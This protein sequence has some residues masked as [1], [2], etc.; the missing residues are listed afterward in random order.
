MA[1]PKILKLS[2]FLAHFASDKRKDRKFCFITGAGASKESGIRTGAELV[3]VWMDDT[4]T[5]YG[6]EETARW[7]EENDIDENTLAPHYSKIY[8]KRFELD[9]KEGFDFLENEMERAKPSCGYS[10]LVQVLANTSHNIVITVNFDSMVEDAMFTYTDKRPLV[11]GH[12]SLAGFIGPT[13]TR[14]LIAKI[15]RDVFLAP[16]S[17]LAETA[18][19]AD[20]WAKALTD[21]LKIYTPVVI[22]YGGNDGSL[23]GFLEHVPTIEGGIFWCY[24][25]AG[26]RPAKRITD[27][28]AKHNGWLIP[29]DGFDDMMIQ[30][31]GKLGYPFL[32]EK[33]IDIAKQKAKRYWE[34]IEKIQ[35][36]AVQSIDTNKAIADIFKK[37]KTNEWTVAL[38]ALREKDINKRHQVLEDGLRQ[39]PDSSSLLGAYAVSLQEAR[40]YDRADEYFKKAL[41]IDPDDL[42]VIIF[43]AVFLDN[44]RHEY[45]K[46]EEC[47]RKAIELAP[48][49]S[50]ANGSYAGFLVHIRRDNGR[51]EA[52]Y[53]KALEFDPSDANVTGNYA[54]LLL[55]TGRKAEAKALIDRA[56]SFNPDKPGLLAE[57]WFYRYANLYKKYGEK[58]YDELVKLIGDGARSIG[59]SFEDNIALAKKEGHPHLDKL[60]KLN[61]IITEDAP[62]SILDS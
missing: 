48:N 62:I 6:L 34:Q 3:K 26:G 7:M 5:F 43:Y 12:E 30:L 54:Q 27:L 4:K 9:V 8:D 17:S 50:L 28:V 35:K 37:T 38:E 1:D 44:I 53:K 41:K 15:H 31:N 10:V 16:K 51:A 46:A 18:C 36:K 11:C 52:Y 40:N 33:I 61:K 13:V 39:F 23:M 2:T 24:L 49:N 55:A 22:G 47:Y 21:I 20:D 60:E 57:L 14:P 25:E 58:A 59:W 32:G 42:K 56:F 29:I 19:L 45:D